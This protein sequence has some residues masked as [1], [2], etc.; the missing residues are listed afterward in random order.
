MFLLLQHTFYRVLKVA[1]R[2]RKTSP[3]SRQRQNLRRAENSKIGRIYHLQKIEHRKKSCLCS[4]FYNK[5]AETSL[6]RP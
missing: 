1:H 6:A 4:N 2:K 5:K 3:T